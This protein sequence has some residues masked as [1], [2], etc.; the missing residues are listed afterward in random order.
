MVDTVDEKMTLIIVSV[1]SLRI[2]KGTFI[3]KLR[4][5]CIQLHT[6]I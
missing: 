1:L 3:T 6:T 5:Y 4:V 2:T